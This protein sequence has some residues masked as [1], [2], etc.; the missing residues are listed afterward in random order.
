MNEFEKQLLEEFKANDE[1]IDDML[2]EVITRL[3]RIHLRAEDQEAAI[4]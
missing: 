1:E 4:E 3:Q 2:E